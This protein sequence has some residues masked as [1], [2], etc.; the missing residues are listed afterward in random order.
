MSQQ[1]LSSHK[2]SVVVADDHEIIR[3]SLIDALT[4]PG[5][6]T[7]DGLQ[8]LAQADNGLTAIAAIKQHRPDLLLLDITMPL[9]SGAQ[10]LND[11]RR[12]SPHTRIVVFTGI[13]SAGL[14][15]SLIEDGIH[16][17]FSKADPIA[18]LLDALPAILTGGRY[19]AGRF[20]RLLDT[21]SAIAL[22]TPRER[23][24]LN[25][26]VAGKTNKE[27]A[28]VMGISAKTV[29][30]HR[31]SLMQKLDVHSVVELIALALREG[32]LEQP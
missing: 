2:Q 31:S 5:R 14:V 15:A 23:Q 12:W 1:A 28:A 20:Q 18:E 16:G 8:L 7:R 13:E 26:V 9:A 11:I 10:I 29:D 32:L 27:I 30:K 22:L 25:M 3:Q 21:H 24:T 6:V 4:Q 19:I 17:L